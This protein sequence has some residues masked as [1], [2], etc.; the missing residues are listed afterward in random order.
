M[1][2]LFGPDQKKF[3]TEF[4]NSEPSPKRFGIPKNEIGF[5]NN[6]LGIQS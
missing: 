5:P 6:K 4:H 1:P 2:K 3:T